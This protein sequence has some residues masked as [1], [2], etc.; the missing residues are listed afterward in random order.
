MR[1]L[2]WALAAIT[3]IAVA[4]CG[5]SDGGGTTTSPDPQSSDS[6]A[7]T[8]PS[9]GASP[10]PAEQTV[11]VDLTFTGVLAGHVT[12]AVIGPKFACGTPTF[13][14][15][16]TLNDLEVE[17]GGRT[18]AFGISASSYSGPGRMSGNVVVTLADPKNTADGY[19]SKEVGDAEV[20]VAED[21]KSGTATA[22]LYRDLNDPKPSVQ[23]TGTWRCPT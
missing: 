7:S 4:G 11:S 15:L 18:W 22:G 23:V 5:G 6:S 14:D 10:S 21:T 16:F 20:V 12:T 1:T 13:P 2:R 17:L 9:G 19:L 8:G 3:A